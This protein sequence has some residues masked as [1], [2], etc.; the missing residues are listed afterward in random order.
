M[1]RTM[2]ISCMCAIFILPVA[3]VTYAAAPYD[4][5]VTINGTLLQTYSSTGCPAG[6]PAPSTETCWNVEGIYGNGAIVIERISPSTAAR[7]EI[8]VTTT[9]TNTD[10]LRLINARIRNNTTAVQT[11]T[12]V[13]KRQF[14]KNPSAVA[15]ATNYY[16]I[17]AN[18]TFSPEAGNAFTA[19]GWYTNP[20]PGTPDQMDSDLTFTV[21]CDGGGCTQYADKKTG[22]YESP[23]LTDRI[24]QADF[25]VTLKQS[26][27]T[28]S[29]G[30]GVKMS[31]P[32]QPEGGNVCEECTPKAQLNAFCMTTYLTAKAF[33]CPSCV[34]EDGQ[35]AEHAKVKLFASTNWDNLI[36]DMARGKGEHLT[37]LAA[38]LKIPANRQ[39][40]FFELVQEKYRTSPGVETP[41]QVVA[42]LHETWNS[43]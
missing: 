28:F 41:E 1:N 13:F 20:T 22:E 37:S 39:S 12:I 32:D 26:G 35:V 34:T 18:G 4:I 6:P 25:I 11:V 8:P 23:G 30:T 10:T 7:V 9:D 14:K 5:S 3:A 36:Q 2:L 33:G 31:A 27:S 15:P 24:L 42:S 40:E 43:R 38:L 16:K 19:K 21:T 29:T 17:I